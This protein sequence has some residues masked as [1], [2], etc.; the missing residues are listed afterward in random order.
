M[1]P[2]QL[3]SYKYC[4]EILKENHN[5]NCKLHSICL[6]I[7]NILSQFGYGSCKKSN[8]GDESKCYKYLSYFIY[9]YIKSSSS[10]EDLKNL[11]TQI[12]EAKNFYLTADNSCIIDNFAISNA[13]FKKKKDLYLHGE[14]LYWIK[15]KEIL[16]EVEEK[17]S[18]DEYL[19]KCSKI[20]T[21]IVQKDYC[22]GNETFNS[23]LLVFQKNFNN[24]RDYLKKT[25]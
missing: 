24:A 2:K 15:E 20:Y 13:D 3:S 6:N 23:D 8:L 14:N 25:A 17:T 5:E 21:D 4:T 22:K 7:E 9:S 10:C 1:K 18:F 11:Y 19:K 12:N 16:N